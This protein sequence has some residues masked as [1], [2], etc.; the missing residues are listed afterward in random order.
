MAVQKPLDKSYK[1]DGQKDRFSLLNFVWIAV[2]GLQILQMFSWHMR[3]GV[4]RFILFHSV[5]IKPMSF[6]FSFKC[7]IAQVLDI[8]IF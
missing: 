1:S 2:Y 8:L 5:P 6:S 3:A 7:L 4:E